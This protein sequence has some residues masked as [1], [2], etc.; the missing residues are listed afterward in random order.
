LGGLPCHATLTLALE[1]EPDSKD[2][3]EKVRKFRETDYASRCVC[4]RQ[5]VTRFWQ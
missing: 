1:L 2:K 5:D 3:K 4:A